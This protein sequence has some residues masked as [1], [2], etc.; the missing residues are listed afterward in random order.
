M[1]FTQTEIPGAWIVDPEPIRDSRGAFAR[2]FCERE[3]AQRGLETRFPQHSVS[4]NTARGTLRGLHFQRAPHEET[5]LVSCTAGAIYDVCVDLRPDSPTFRQWR[6]LELSAASG[7]Q[8][9]IPA[10]CAHGF[11]TLADN[12][13]VR[14]LIS[15][16]YAAEA[17]DGVRYDDPAFAVRWPIEIT[18]IA[19]KDRSWPD[20]RS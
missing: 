4:F 8:F 1:I 18:Q 6:A 17:S 7:R 13:E 16:F 11:Q 12:T 15:E 9:L 2:T 5:K 14:Y 10:G 20:F 3:F 19:D